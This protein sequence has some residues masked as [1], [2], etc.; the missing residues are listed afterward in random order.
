MFCGKMSDILQLIEIVE[1][2]YFENT[3]VICFFDAFS[4]TLKLFLVKKCQ[5][6]KIKFNFQN[7]KY[8]IKKIKKNFQQWNPFHLIKTRCSLIFPFNQ[9]PNKLL[10]AFLA[11]MFSPVLYLQNKNIKLCKKDSHTIKHKHTNRSQRW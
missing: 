10:K 8:W 5:V 4:S 1:K 11:I 2:V 9:S 6:Y 3:L 7:L